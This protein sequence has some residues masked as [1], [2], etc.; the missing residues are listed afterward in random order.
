VKRILLVG[1]GSGG[2]VYPLVAVAN[3]LREKA[4]QNGIDL[5]LRLWGDGDFLNKAADE[6]GIRS[7]KIIGGK[8]RRYFSLLNIGDFFKSILGFIQSV[9][10][11]YWYMPD[12]V[13][14]KGG[15]VS[16][17]PA[18][19]AKLYM[20]PVYIH[21]SDSTPGLANSV[22]SKIAK[23][24]F[25]SFESSAKYYSPS[26]IEVVGNPVRKE[27]LEGDKNTALGVFNFS[28]DKKTIL[29]LGGSQGAKKINDLVLESI[30]QLTQNYQ[31]VH[32]CGES[33][34]KTVLEEVEKYQKE[35][36]S[37]YGNQIASNYRLY[38]FLS[39]EEIKSAYVLADVIVARGGAGLIFEI[40]AS[41]KPA[42]IIPLSLEASR[43]DQIANAEEF[44]RYGAIVLEE[45]NL[46][47]HILI[48]QI[49][50]LL[51]AENYQ[52]ISEKIKSF[53]RPDAADKIAEAL[54]Q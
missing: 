5:D 18:I 32:Q 50:H 34:H 54:L 43:G 15:Y 12:T 45:D 10:L 1:G 13:F 3:A 24:I 2:H 53:S 51:R 37:S 9:W 49:E 52:T 29:F 21:E 28:P 7:A 19:A 41:A 40:A 35:G 30:I 8:V 47:I 22:V 33:Q 46:T 27:I 36:Q 4:Q 44:A 11:M 39:L 38:P 16:V 6:S 20:I 25:I 17:M 31:V 26:K 48:N 42:I 23:K 14:T